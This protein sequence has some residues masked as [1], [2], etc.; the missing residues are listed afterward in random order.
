VVPATLDETF[1]F[2]ADAANLQRLTPPWLH[3][4]I[5]TAMP[6]QMRDGAVIDYRIRVHGLPMPWRSRIVRWEPGICFV[7]RQLVGPYR[8]WNHEHRF[9]PVAG[10]TL[11]VDHVEYVPRLR[12]L[13]GHL[14]RR[15]LERI[16]AFRHHALIRHFAR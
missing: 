6:V 12:L 5:T 10:G 7:D 13:T 3:F 9:E 16:F 8:W 1:A 2:F 11:V 14:V 4:R 15:E